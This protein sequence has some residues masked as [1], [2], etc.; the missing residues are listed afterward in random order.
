MVECLN[1]KKT[2]CYY[3]TTFYLFL[4][5]FRDNRKNPFLKNSKNHIWNDIL[6]VDNYSVRHSTKFNF[7]PIGDNF[8]I[9]T[10]LF[11]NRFVKNAKKMDFLEI[12]RKIKK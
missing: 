7:K 1:T 8:K 4:R 11:F 12:S 6:G 10:F 3:L 2:F 5:V 9:G